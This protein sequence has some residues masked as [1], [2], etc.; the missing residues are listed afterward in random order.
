MCVNS[1]GLT[2]PLRRSPED[3]FLDV[4][5]GNA[6]ILPNETATFATNSGP[7]GE[8]YGNYT[9]NM[10]YEQVRWIK[11]ELSKVNRTETPWVFA[12]SHR[13]MCEFLPKLRALPLR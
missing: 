12:M 9:D 6:S 5:K 8:L 11:N 13:P 2:T 3:S 1:S 7:F 10:N 4:T